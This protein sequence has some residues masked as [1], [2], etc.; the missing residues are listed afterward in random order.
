M[1]NVILIGMPGVG[2]STAGVLAAKRLGLGFVDTDILLQ[3]AEGRALR[4]II[5]AEGLNGFCDI[6]SR[7]VRQLA[8]TATV[9][10]TGG[11]VIYREPA[12][13][14]LKTLGCIVYLAIDLP[15]LTERV[16]NLRDRGVVLSPGMGLEQLFRER[17]P[18]YRRYAEI[19]ID[20]GRQNADRVAEA[21][22]RSVPAF[23]TPGA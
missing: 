20:C 3:Q 7:H 6:E 12:M 23:A 11:S 21:I 10:A 17:E 14:H 19:T 4:S 9:I 22:V 15:I 5:A 8:V 18:L 16:S 1:K 13:T 2:K